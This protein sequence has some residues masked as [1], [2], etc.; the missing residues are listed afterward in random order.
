MSRRVVLALVAALLIL[1]PWLGSGEH[2]QLGERSRRTLPGSFARLKQGH[3]CY[4]LQG[5]APAEAVVFVHG[6]SSPS[7]VWGQLPAALRGSGY[8]TLTYDL[9]GRGWSDRPWADYNLDLFVGQ[10]EALMRKV[11][12]QRSVHLVGLSMGGVI[13]SEFTLRH[14]DMVTSLTLVDPAGFAVEAPPG[15]GLITAPLV[16][17]WLMQTFGD[18]ILLA[19]NAASVHDKTRVG[20]LVRR[21]TPQLEYAG[22]KR[23]WLSTLRNM[24]LD[25]FTARYGELGRT[26]VPIEVFWGVDDEVTPVAGAKLAAQLL[27][28]AAV[29]EIADAGHL[30]HYEKP[31]EV[32]AQM[33]RFLGQIRAPLQDGLRR[34]GIDADLEQGAPPRECKECDLGKKPAQREGAY[35][36]PSTGE[37]RGPD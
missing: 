31:D 12:L 9:Y 37:R 11:G 6:L 4:E 15:A 8:L 26:T 5:D 22:Y 7:Y 19:G 23:A 34:P 27:P 36:R 28:K 25:D 29:H 14:P 30:S 3:T 1:P 16:G 17:D 18:R 33:L 21:F 32:S 24:P 35:S 20:D 10:L 13:A 2:K